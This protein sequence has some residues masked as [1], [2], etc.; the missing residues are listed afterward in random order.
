MGIGHT[1]RL[2]LGRLTALALASVGCLREPSTPGELPPDIVLEHATVRQYRGSTPQL[3]AQTPAIAFYRQGPR[4]GH[5]EAREVVVDSSSDG[6]RVNAV[7]LEGDVGSGAFDGEHVRAV[8][9]AGTTVTS[10]RA[11]FDRTQGLEG[12]AST[13]AGVLVVSPSLRLEAAAGRLDLEA[14]RAVLDDVRTSLGPQGQ[15]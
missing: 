13:D 7:H 11:H 8:T 6:L 14:G 9:A 10:P 12:T 4:A 5:L 2:G 15:P 1:G 3:V